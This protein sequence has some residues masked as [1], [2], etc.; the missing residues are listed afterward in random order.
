MAPKKRR[1][2]NAGP[3]V[4]RPSPKKQDQPKPAATVKGSAVRGR[5]AMPQ[6]MSFRG[7]GIRALVASVIFFVY[8]MAVGKASPTEAFPFAAFAFVLMLPLG[9]VMDRAVLRLRMRKWQR[10]RPPK[11]GPRK[12]E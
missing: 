8:V 12:P 7:L 1:R 3:P 9:F 6:P 10:M 5:D 4:V 2:P 11:S